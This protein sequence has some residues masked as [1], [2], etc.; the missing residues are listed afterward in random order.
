M[1]SRCQ[2]LAFGLS[3]NKFIETARIWPDA[4]N[5]DFRVQI[6]QRHTFIFT[7]LYCGKG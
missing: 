1:K 7:K 4:F 5:I 6:Y 2:E 3:G